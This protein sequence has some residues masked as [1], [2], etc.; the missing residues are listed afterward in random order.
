MKTT[1]I[2]LRKCLFLLFPAC[3]FSCVAIAQG[4]HGKPVVQKPVVRK[5]VIQNKALQT[6]TVDK[7]SVKINQATPKPGNNR[8][9]A[10]NMREFKTTPAYSVRQSSYASNF[11]NPSK[12]FA[13]DDGSSLK[14]NFRKSTDGGQA[15][16]ISSTQVK[17][18]KETKDGDWKCVTSTL[19]INANSTNFGVSDYQK[20]AAN[21]YPGAVYTFENLMNGSF[22]TQAGARNPIV[23]STDNK[24]MSGDTY[25]EVTNPTRATI[26]NGIAQIYRGFSSSAGNGATTMQLYESYTSADWTLKLNAGGS[27]W[28]V[29]INNSFKSSDKSQHRYLTIDV[30]KTLF[31]INTLP[32]DNGFFVD[33][34]NET[35][36]PNMMFISSVAYGIRILANLEITFK[37]SEVA[38]EFNAKYKSGF[39]NASVDLNY[40]QNNSSVETKI[41]AYIVGGPNEGIITFDRDKLIS[42]LNKILAGAT[43]QNAQAISYSLCDMAGNVIGS[44]SATD[45]FAYRNCVPAKNPPLLKSAFVTVHCG[46]DGKDRDTHYRYALFS[47]RSK[48]VKMGLVTMKGMKVSMASYV[49]NSDNSRFENNSANNTNELKLDKS[50]GDHPLDEFYEQG[51]LRIL[52]EPNGHDEWQITTL[53]LTLNFDDGSSKFVQWNNIVMSHQN[54]TKDLYFRGGSD[55]TLQAIN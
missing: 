25:V 51:Y 24:N 40:L 47:S 5:P 26:Q 4:I 49:N 9:A 32:P 33:S 53:K 11:N 38:N 29:S 3:L 45:Q 17:P 8:P 1:M 43:Y 54:K 23:I 6:Q 30:K 52:I 50:T 2:L 16:D 35:A 41:N 7:P 14:I 27:A 42:T 19:Q 44:Q 13:M 46:A 37:S 39:Y 20:Q 15:D 34:K 31:T 28:G 18:G 21:I 10:L 12:T 48:D 36:A 22:R 55:G